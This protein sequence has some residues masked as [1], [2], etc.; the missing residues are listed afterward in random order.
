MAKFVF[1]FEALL[2]QRR[3]VERQRTLDLAEIERARLALE[4]RIRAFQVEVEQERGELRDQLLSARSG[5]AAPL[6]LR[7]VRFQAN[8]ALKLIAKA[9]HTVIQLAGVHQRLDAAR[10]SLLQAVMERKAVEALRERQ[11]EEWKREQDRRQTAAM[12]DLA[13]VRAARLAQQ[14][15]DDAGPME[16]A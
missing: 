16:A 10:L 2:T 9:Q 14:G 6:D 13:G 3:A 7:G 1:Q 5:G 15:S 8:S 11:L 4:E 12:D